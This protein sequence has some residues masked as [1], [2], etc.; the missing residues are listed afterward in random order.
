[1]GCNCVGLCECAYVNAC[2]CANTITC[3]CARS[4][5]C[6]CEFCANGGWRTNSMLIDKRFSARTALSLPKVLEGFF[7]SPMAG[8]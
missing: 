6:T 4:N 1:M 8:G 5:A 3:V 7:L 2:V